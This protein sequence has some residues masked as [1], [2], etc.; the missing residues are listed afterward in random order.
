MM[1][2][3]RDMAKRCKEKLAERAGGPVKSFDVADQS[4]MRVASRYGPLAC[5]VRCK[6]LKTE[7]FPAS[8][9]LPYKPMAS[10]HFNQINES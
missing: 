4:Q 6:A 1:E 8:L 9:R 2:M 7:W 5:L 3:A 10:Y